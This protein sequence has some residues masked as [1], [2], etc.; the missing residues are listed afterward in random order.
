VVYTGDAA[1]TA[2]SAA[3]LGEAGAELAIVHMRPPHTA[4]VVEPLATALAELA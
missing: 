4:A 3:A 2:A 1:E